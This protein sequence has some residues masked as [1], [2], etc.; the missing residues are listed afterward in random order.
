MTAIINSSLVNK[1]ASCY[2]TTFY[3]KSLGKCQISSHLSV[4]SIFDTCF[5]KRQSTES[6][7][8]KITNDILFTLDF[9]SC[10]ISI[11]FD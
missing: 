6:A 10:C 7:L 5:R 4:F 11:V 8:L 1:V 2:S 3:F 9:G